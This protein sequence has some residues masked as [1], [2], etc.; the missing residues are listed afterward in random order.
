VSPD[1]AIERSRGLLVVLDPSI[2]RVSVSGNIL[3]L[4]KPKSTLAEKFLPIKVRTSLL[5]FVS[6]VSVDHAGG[7]TPDAHLAFICDLD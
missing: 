4:Q 7:E 3:N 6:K 1:A 5:T 2:L